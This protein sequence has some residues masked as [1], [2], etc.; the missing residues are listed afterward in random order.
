[1]NPVTFMSLLQIVIFSGLLLLTPLVTRIGSGPIDTLYPGY[2]QRTARWDQP[3]Q[4]P[5]DDPPPL[6]RSHPGPTDEVTQ[7]AR[8][9]ARTLA[10][11]PE[12]ISW[13]AVVEKKIFD[14]T[15]QERMKMK[16]PRLKSL[17]SD[18]GLQQSARFHSADMIQRQ[19]FAHASPD[20]KTQFDRMA[21]I[22]R[23]LIGAGGE[24]I[25][26][27]RGYGKQSPD[28]L[29]KNVVNDWMDSIGHRANILRP[30][31]SHLGV[32]AAEKGDTIKI[33]QNFSSLQVQLNTPMPLE[34]NKGD[35]LDFAVTPVLQSAAPVRYEYML[36]DKGVPAFGPYSINDPVIGRE[37]T[38]GDY[39]LRFYFEKPSTSNT[40]DYSIYP[41]PRI[42]VRE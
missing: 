24:N 18:D 25:W 1:M 32:G 8:I 19:F 9:A 33:T 34:A 21:V 23:R 41:G 30:T 10:K 13:M 35:T 16:L 38:S 4:P 7:F 5:S 17:K 37:I 29:V 36:A 2:G 3:E 20:G 26:M 42:I 31:F 40:I 15:N 28:E 14:L 6:L 22:H 11:P 12:G 27:G 39:Q